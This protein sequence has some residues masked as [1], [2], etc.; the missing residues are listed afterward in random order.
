MRTALPSGAVGDADAALH[1]AIVAI[2][3]R[4][5]AIYTLALWGVVGRGGGADNFG[6]AH[7]SSPNARA[8]DPSEAKT[9]C[10]NPRSRPRMS[11]TSGLPCT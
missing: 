2:L 6:G 8:L 10:P 7:T 11:T 9:T 4:A 3:L 5:L 1:D